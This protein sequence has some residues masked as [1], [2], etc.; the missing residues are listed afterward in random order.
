V[1]VVIDS[2]H[3]HAYIHIC[4][5]VCDQ[6]ILPISYYYQHALTLLSSPPLL[7]RLI[8]SYVILF[9]NAP[10]SFPFLIPIIPSPGYIIIIP[11]TCTL[12][13]PDESLH[14]IASLPTITMFQYWYSYISYELTFISNARSHYH[15]IHSFIFFLASI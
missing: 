9:Y 3:G 6:S 10:L 12:L 5:Y 7:P 15:S 11:N 1:V 4:M 14:A 2:T 13:L 8:M